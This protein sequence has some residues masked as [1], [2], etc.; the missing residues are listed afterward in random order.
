MKIETLMTRDVAVCHPDDTLHLAARRL[1]D[2]DCG[3]APVVDGAGQLVGMITD[4][5]ICMAG[6]FRG[7]PLQH[8]RVADVMSRQTRT[9]GADQDA[10]EALRT[11]GQHKVRRLPVVDA[12]GR[13]AGIV[14]LA[15]LALATGTKGAGRGKLKA[16]PLVETLRAISSPPP[17]EPE[18]LVVEVRP[19]ARGKEATREA[20]AKTARK[21]RSRAR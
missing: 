14:A 4:R 6:Y 16:D 15:D 10:L 21:A 7:Q 19:R 13:L 17:R 3:A 9:V 11:M 12:E 2:R 18:V 20:P 5:D 8:L 1:W